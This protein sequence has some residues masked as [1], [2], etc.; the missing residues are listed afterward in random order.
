M[1]STK[2]FEVET[3]MPERLA[4]TIASE[5]A[6]NARNFADILEVD[7]ESDLEENGPIPLEIGGMR[8]QVVGRTLQTSDPR[9]YASRML[10]EDFSTDFMRK[11]VLEKYPVPAHES[12]KEVGHLVGSLEVDR[13]PSL[14]T[15]SI[16]ASSLIG[17]LMLAR[18]DERYLEDQKHKL[19]N[20]I[21]IIGEL[22]GEEERD[23]IHENASGFAE[24]LESIE[25]RGEPE[26]TLEKWKRQKIHD[27]PKSLEDYDLFSRSHAAPA[28]LT[29]T[30][31][32]S[33]VPSNPEKSYEDAIEEAAEILR[34]M[35]ESREHLEDY[36][37]ITQGYSLIYD[38]GNYVS[39]ELASEIEGSSYDLTRLPQ[40]TNEE[41]VNEFEDYIEDVKESIYG[42]LDVPDV[43]IET[44]K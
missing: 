40:R 8:S 23:Y 42:E 2:V 22:N 12:I 11:K 7:L 28:S 31:L 14:N 25:G 37:D 34:G 27:S 19:R 21:D 6:E 33:A 5:Y 35:G 10:E 39:A 15:E 32:G 20:N 41:I 9:E 16:A 44:K 13:T 29:E 26:R 24:D 4:E 36:A 1:S 30:F 43:A 18:E 3:D 38:V 17:N